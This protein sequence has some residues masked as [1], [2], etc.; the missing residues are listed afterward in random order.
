M[1]K[2]V[3]KHPLIGT[4]KRLAPGPHGSQGVLKGSSARRFIR[5]TGQILD[6]QTA[7]RYFNRCVRCRQGI[8]ERRA[9]CLRTCRLPS[10]CIPGEDRCSNGPRLSPVAD[11]EPQARFSVS[12]E[13]S[14]E[15]SVVLPISAS[16][17][18]AEDGEAAKGCDGWVL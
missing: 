4:D 10:A 16:L 14:R 17:V 11:I 12:A 18:R 9:V 1:R 15:F 2:R 5:K 8:A 3:A 13:N 6:D 7:G